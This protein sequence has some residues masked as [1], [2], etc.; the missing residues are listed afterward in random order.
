MFVFNISNFLCCFVCVFPLFTHTLRKYNFRLCSSGSLKNHMPTSSYYKVNDSLPSTSCMY[1]ILFV[2]MEGW[3]MESQTKM[4]HI[5]YT[6]DL[7]DCL[8]VVVV[9]KVIHV[10][11]LMLNLLSSKDCFNLSTNTVSLPNNVYLFDFVTKVKSS[12]L[13]KFE[14]MFL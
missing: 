8:V 4:C 5:L 7:V 6:Q 13:L 10:H 3:W 11:V 1:D 12:E 2:T 9:L 14:N